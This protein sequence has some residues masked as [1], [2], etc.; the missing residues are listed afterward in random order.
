MG[1]VLNTRTLIDQT[2]N[3][4]TILAEEQLEIG[5][6][7]YRNTASIL[8]TANEI[9]QEV[10]R[11]TNAENGKISKT[12]QYQTA[13]SIVSE[14]VS[15]AA[16]SASGLYLAKTTSYQ[17]PDAIVTEAVRQA[18]AAA[19]Q[20]YIAKTSTYQTADSIKNEAVRVS[21]V[22][23]NNTYLAKSGN[24]QTV[25][26]IIGQAEA[27]ADAAADTA[28]NAS[29]AKTSTYQSAQA[30]VNTAVAS[31]A[32]AAGN[33]YIAK[34]TS[35][36]TADAIVQT[37]ESYTDNNAYK[38]VSGITITSSGIDI[39]GS[40]Y[41]CI[42][43]GG[44]FR[45]TSGNF[46]IKSDAE[47]T[48][49]VIWSGA[50]TA[51]GSSFRVK[52]NGEVTLT[53]LLVLNEQG[54]ESEVNLKTANLWKLGYQTVKSWS[55]NSI[56][57]SNNTTINFNTAASV[58]LTGG[59][60]GSTFTVSNSGN[61]RTSSATIEFDRTE[62]YVKTALGV[63]SDHKQT[64]NVNDANRT[65]TPLTFVIDGSY[66]YEQGVSTGT[67]AVGFY[68]ESVWSSGNKTITLTNSK[69]KTVS[70]PDAQDWSATYTSNG[71]MSVSAY[72]GGKAISSGAM[73]DPGY[74]RGW[75]DCI[76]AMTSLVRY[77]RSADSYGG[78]S[79]VH[80]VYSGGQYVNVG[81]G[82]WKTTSANAWSKPDPKS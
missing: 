9:R 76:G 57:L 80:Y 45:V 69:T 74:N 26:D 59:W 11:A 28:K 42:A 55:T 15:Q 37:A 58:T 75:N 34:T 72:V 3:K 39:S 50:S 81:T 61:N 29:I 33:T 36:Q 49:Y 38:Q 6:Q 20:N 2:A 41:V 7:V 10:Q 25:N 51:A 13:D 27:L 52:K 35:Y 77:T 82:W 56:T 70:I 62:S 21:G 46:G 73:T 68:S 12:T 63:N 66:C 54:T 30:I 31:A 22:N 48:D 78:E 79:R 40:Q 64:L 44:Y 16:S 71:Q 53:K 14:A 65:N 1:A 67:A 60:S 4:V 47:S 8:V 5:D 43:S 32:T 24:Y 19:G 17:T 18:N 23:A